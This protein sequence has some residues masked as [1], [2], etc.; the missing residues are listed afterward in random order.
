L[1]LC[2]GRAYQPALTGYE[3]LI[4]QGTI[5]RVADGGTGGRLAELYDWLHEEGSEPLL[6][7][8][9][10]VSEGAAWIR[11]RQ[12]TGTPQELLAVARHAL[13]EGVPGASH[14]HAW[15]VPVDG[16]SV[17]PKWL[18]SQLTGL[19]ASAFVTDE[20]RRVLA[21]LGIEVRRV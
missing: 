6:L 16:R 10:R 2:V 14:Y 3:T 5:V 8:Q 20:A 9:Q 13:A 21:Q 12:V 19:P 18:V 15:Y 17:G 1:L 7:G 4:P 11:G